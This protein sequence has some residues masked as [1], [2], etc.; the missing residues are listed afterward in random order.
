VVLP[1]TGPDG[2]AE[3]VLAIPADAA[4]TEI[5]VDEAARSCSGTVMHVPEKGVS[6]ISDIDDTIRI[7]MV[8]N[9]KEL[10]RRTFGLPYVPVP[11]MRAAYAAMADRGAVFHYVSGSPWQLYRPIQDF[12]T[13][14]GFPAGSV[15]LKQLRF[16]DSSFIKFV[17]ADQL[18]YKTEII[19][20][21]IADFPER[22]F[23]LVGDSGEKDPEVYEAISRRHPDRII[24]VAIRDLGNAPQSRYEK[25]FGALPGQFLLFRDAAELA[26]IVAGLPQ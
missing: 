17:Q 1:E 19:E 2:I 16:L 25:L 4:D 13:S 3:S 20:G 8:L 14:H 15:H 23:V 7:S 11:G 18:A 22:T 5:I 9:K 10:I 6:V 12:M 26:G 24:A 21:I